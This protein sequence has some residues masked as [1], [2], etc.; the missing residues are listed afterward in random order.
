MKLEAMIMNL[1]P[2]FRSLTEYYSVFIVEK[3]YRSRLNIVSLK[4]QTWQNC[5]NWIC[6]QEHSGEL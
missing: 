4:F 3:A 5:V 1:K 6:I 2:R